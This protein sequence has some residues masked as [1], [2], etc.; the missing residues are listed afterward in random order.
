MLPEINFQ[1][2]MIADVFNL[3]LA[4][5]NVAITLLDPMLQLANGVDLYREASHTSPLV[6]SC[7]PRVQNGSWVCSDRRP[8]PACFLFC[9]SGLVPAGESQ[10]DCETY[11][12]DNTTNF[13]CVPAGVVII[14]GLDQ[15]DDAVRRIEAFSQDQLSQDQL[16]HKEI[17]L[18]SYNLA[19]LAENKTLISAATE[20]YNGKLVTCGGVYQKSCSSLKD[21]YRQFE[22]HSVL[23]SLQEGGSVTVLGPSLQ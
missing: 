12:Q 16:T 18:N 9:P 20:W 15:Q 17:D 11:R 10:V 2:P 19:S 21:Q 14:G 5:A 6:V 22:V 7:P 3:G 4:L 13:S 23:R 1:I 8:L